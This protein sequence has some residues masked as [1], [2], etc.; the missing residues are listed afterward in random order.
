LLFT[1]LYEAYEIKEDKMGGEVRPMGDEEK[2]TK[3]WSGNLRGRDVLGDLYV[4]G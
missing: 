2:H 4:A 1:K 3:F